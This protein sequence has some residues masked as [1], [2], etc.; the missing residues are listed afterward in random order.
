MTAQG[1]RYRAVT[2]EG[3]TVESFM[4]LPGLLPA[5]TARWLA[6]LLLSMA[7]PKVQR[8]ESDPRLRFQVA[9]EAVMV[10]TR[11]LSVMVNVGIP[12]HQ[13]IRFIARGDDATLNEALEE[14]AGMLESGHSL[15]QA[16][17]KLPG[18]FSPMFQGYARVAETSGNLVA[19]LGLL[20]ENLEEGVTLRRKVRSSL[21]YPFF[22]MLGALL[23]SGILVFGI[24]PMMTPTLLEIGVRMPFLTRA[25][26]EVARFGSH[27]VVLTGAAMVATGVWAYFSFIFGQTGR[28]TMSRRWFDR[29]LLA[30]PL[31]GRLIRLYTAAQVLSTLAISLKVG[32][33]IGTAL[34]DAESVVG[35][36]TLAERLGASRRSLEEGNE[37]LESLELSGVLTR[38]AVLV[39]ESGAEAGHLD[40]TV[41]L[42]ARQS[43]EELSDETDALSAL[44][45]P[46]VL[47]FM[48]L[49]VGTV[50]VAT[51]LPWIELIKSI[52]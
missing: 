11:Q 1:F 2:P 49:L 30:L 46:V 38:G 18:V 9:P 7:F 50:A 34:K 21:T 51:F 33:S 41:A 15:S 26:V 16:A 35:N 42:L 48:S 40:E 52:L 29:A 20:A 4:I 5:G 23:L 47:I 43:G 24:V 25:V 8:L 19:T 12:I 39:I 22:L 17:A 3:K 13:A 6:G 31:A 32:I 44:L 14:M 36:V 10:C 45:E 37:L 28:Y 27:P